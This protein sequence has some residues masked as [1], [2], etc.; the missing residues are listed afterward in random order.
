M[1][2]AIC[3]VVNHSIERSNAVLGLLYFGRFSEATSE[4]QDSVGKTF[5]APD[6]N[7]VLE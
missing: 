6:L 4:E 5:E 7:N 1:F 2:T 3:D